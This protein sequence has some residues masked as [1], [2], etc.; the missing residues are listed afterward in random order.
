MWGICVCGGGGEGHG[1]G[2]GGH[3]GGLVGVL[4]MS[5]ICV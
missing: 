2:L 3:S 4:A 5:N 1:G